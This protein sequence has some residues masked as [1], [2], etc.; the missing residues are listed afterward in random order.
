[1]F[2]KFIKNMIIK[3]GSLSNR[4]DEDMFNFSCVVHFSLTDTFPPKMLPQE[5]FLK[6]ISRKKMKK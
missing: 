6:S 5:L 2:S 1:M 4:Q 3:K